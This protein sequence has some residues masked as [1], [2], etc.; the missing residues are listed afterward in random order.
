VTERHPSLASILLPGLR[1]ID[2]NERRTTDQA[3]L[4]DVSDADLCVL[5]LEMSGP[6]P[7]VHEILDIGAVRVA[8]EEGLPE[9]ASFGTRVRPKHI[10]TADQG[11]LKVVG[12]SPRAW[13]DA[14][15]LEEAMEELVEFGRGAILAGWGIRLDLAFL[16][17]ALER[18]G[19][20]WPFEPIVLDVQDVARAV[21]DS[22]EHGIDSWNLGRVADRL[23]IGRLGEHGAL[24]DAYATYDVLSRLVDL[25]RE[26]APHA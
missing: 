9:E 15:S 10:G 25:A 2:L 1:F 6:N 24:A 7:Q 16:L 11:A 23:G 8:L 4:S 19:L 12:Y 22:E 14:L 26:G 18:T 20:D 3:E 13:R 21:L 5:D 17:E